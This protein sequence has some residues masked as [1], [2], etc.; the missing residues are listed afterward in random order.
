MKIAI[1]GAGNVGATLAL[2]VVQS[3][4]GDVV[5]LDVVAGLPQGKALDIMQ[6]RAVLGFDSRVEG[7]NDYAGL[8][9]ADVAVITAGLARKPGMSRDDLI[10]MNGSIIR[11]VCEQIRCICPESIIIVVTNPLD[12]MGYLAMKVTGFPRER[13]LGMAGVLDAARFRAFVGDELGVHPRDVSAM[14]LGGHGE[15]M[16]P[17]VDG[18]FAGSGAVKELIGGDRLKA[19]VER[20]RNGGAEIVS[21]LKTGSAYYAPAASVLEMLRAIC[22]DSGDVLPASVFLEGEYGIA[23]CFVGVPVRL[24]RRGLVS[25]EE[26][27]LGEDDLAQLRTSAEAV[28]DL[29]VSNFG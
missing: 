6:A 24:G 20:T 14:V 9:G 26:L 28:K 17:L 10:G 29:C 13:V 5:L 27:D 3:N 4:L 11:G 2:F 19:I 18:A 8:R 7:T 22:N 12:V 16:G 25:V 21:L 23:G 15:S 1:V